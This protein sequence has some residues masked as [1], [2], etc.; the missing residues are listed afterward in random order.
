MN[1]IYMIDSYKLSHREQY[2]KGTKVVYSNFTPRGDRLFNSP[3]KDGKMIAFGYQSFI[4]NFLVDM[5]NENFFALSEDAAVL[6]FK[7]EV[8]E[9]LGT[10]YNVD[11]IRD[12][13]KLGYLPLEIKTLDEGSLVPMKVP[14]LTIKNT[15]P[16]FF[17]LVNYLETVMSAEM[18]KPATAATTAFHYRKIVESFAQETCD[19]KSHVPFQCH[20]FSARGLSGAWDAASTG[21]GHLTS[22]MG[23]DSVNALPHIRLSYGDKGF[24]A[25]SIPATEHS[26]ACANIALEVMQI[27][28]TQGY[29]RSP[30]GADIQRGQAERAFL[31][32]LLTEV[33][34]SGLFSYVADTY[35]FWR[36]LTEIAP[37][38]KEEIMSRDGKVVF[39]PDCYDEETKVLTDNGFKFFKD[40]LPTDLV[41]QV[42]DDGSYEFTKPLKY[43]AEHYE[44]DMIKFKDQKGKLDLFVTPN[45]RMI[46]TRHGKE[47]ITEAKDM[48]G[49]LHHYHH[50]TRS[51]KAKEDT[52]NTLTWKERLAIAFQADGS[53]CTNQEKT[54]IRF[55][56]SKERKISR[57]LNIISKCGYEAVVYDLKDGKKEISTKIDFDITKDFSWVDT[58]CLTAGWCREFIEEVSYWDAHRRSATRFKVDSTTKTVIDKIELIGLSAGYGVFRSEAEDNRK[59]IFAK[60]YTLHIMKNNKLG[61][62]AYTKTV[63]EDFSGKVY[64]VQVPSGR[65]VVKRNRSVLVCGNSGDPVKI[66]CG[67]KVETFADWKT[68]QT[69]SVA[70]G[71]EVIYLEDRK[72]YYDITGDRS[73]N[74]SVQEYYEM[75]ENEAK[76]SIQVLYEQ[77]GGTVNTK[78]YKVLDPHV[79]LIYG[80]SITLERAKEIL[81]RLKDKGFASSN[82]VFGVGSFTYQFVT[83]DTFAHAMKATY[84]EVEG[85]GDGIDLFKDPK[86]GD[87]GKKSAKGLLRVDSRDGKLAL[88]DSQTWHEE[89]GGRLV[90]RFLN[91]YF[92]NKTSLAEIRERI[93]K[94]LA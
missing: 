45:H 84:I 11:H 59:D 55:G 14:V 77:F 83:R 19:D 79:G 28:K 7:K 24:I 93:N 40:L 43:V 87:G 50:F 68:M 13:H 29:I 75:S 69:S 25:G 37:S 16:E 51:A 44:G 10:E 31:K 41:A 22:F 67:Y 39:R 88:S 20:D 54:K 85:V 90:T 64:C 65:L 62:Q 4:K 61:G 47:V 60:V 52:E 1:P 23:T 86:T 48:P 15:K 2:P 49:Q 74:A 94:H 56:L 32:R 33:Y 34:P 89:Q 9:H 5:F 70:V 80:D 46:Y 38:L 27:Q 3:E 36:L 71:T 81:K 66:I 6:P 35:D 21:M 91:G 72:K 53:F 30:N 26:V 73:I 8:E 58:D 78:G 18:W 17:W 57:I 63:V 76:G 82:V 92:V 12:L 42:L